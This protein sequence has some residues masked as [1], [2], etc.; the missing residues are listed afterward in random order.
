MIITA[1]IASSCIMYWCNWRKYVIIHTCLKTLNQ[2]H[3]LL[4]ATTLSTPRWSS[5]FLTTWSRS[6]LVRIARYS[7]SAKW[8]NWWT[9]LMIC[10]VF[11]ATNTAVLMD[12]R[13]HMNVIFESTTF[14]IQIVRRKF[15]YY[16]RVQVVL[17]SIF[18]KP[19]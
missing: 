4:M 17:E 15:S 3:H 6:W 14:K 16:Q 8:P 18:I 1:K 11:V 10:F 13:R 12:R 2:A 19:T 9:F 5:R 7:S